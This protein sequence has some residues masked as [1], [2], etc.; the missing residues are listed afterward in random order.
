TET[1]AGAEALYIP[2]KGSSE[3]IGVLAFQPQEN[4]RLS[5]QD[6]DLL[7]S[8]AGQLGLFLEKEFFRERASETDRLQEMDKIHRTLLNLIS[9]EIR[10]PLTIISSGVKELSFGDY[11]MNSEKRIEIS[12]KL[13]DAIETLKF[14]VD[15]LLT[16]SR[17]TIG[18]FPLQRDTISVRS[19]VE[20]SIETVSR[21][22]R[23]HEIEIIEDTEVP[24]VSVDIVL[25]QKVLGNLLVN[26]ATFSPKK[27][28]IEVRIARSLDSILISV[29]D[30]GFG[31][32]TEDLG[33]IFEKFYQ[34][35]G[36]QQHGIGLGLAV[37]K[38]IVKAHGGKIAAA[39]RPGSGAI[40]TIAL[41]M[42]SRH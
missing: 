22:L 8:V 33:R 13:L 26:A 39:N 15:N 21:S 35:S 10:Y 36:K 28:I 24:P 40:L 37:A 4:A 23:D 18:I 14:T 7:F 42:N 1:L 16:M 38:G 27:S 6:Q 32:A 2:L 25:F 29:S 17:I 20:S 19:L 41:P 9:D 11:P 5:L 34:V 31:L 12:D 3:K 30:Q